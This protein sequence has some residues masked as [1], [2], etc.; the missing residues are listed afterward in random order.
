MD[1][2]KARALLPSARQTIFDT[3]VQAFED[4]LRHKI[5]KAIISHGASSLT[6]RPGEEYFGWDYSYT[7]ADPVVVEHVLD[8]LREEGYIIRWTWF[9]FY[10]YIHISWE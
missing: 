9:W 7:P 3:N 5:R 1:A 10:W 4:Y 6:C 8:K 2:K